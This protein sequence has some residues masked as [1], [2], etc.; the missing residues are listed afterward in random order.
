MLSIL[1]SGAEVCWKPRAGHSKRK[2]LARRK[3]ERSADL[4]WAEGEVHRWRNLDEGTWSD[5]VAAGDRR[6]DGRRKRMT[7]ACSANDHGVTS[8][9]G[10][11]E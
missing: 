11:A 10:W 2:E 4:A 5:S 1:L 9:R 6:T 7:I 3:V 8:W